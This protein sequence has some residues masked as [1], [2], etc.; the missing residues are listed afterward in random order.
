M[1]NEATKYLKSL[2]S[3]DF[4]FANN[5][6]HTILDRLLRQQHHCLRE[7]VGNVRFMV[8]W[9][10][11]GRLFPPSPHPFNKALSETEPLESFWLYPSK[12][13]GSYIPHFPW[14]LMKYTASG[15]LSIWSF[16]IAKPVKKGS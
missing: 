15:F 9:V 5:T 6:K 8:L 11:G 2:E 13:E 10:M 4:Y 14:D 3:F 12:A 7:T 1:D 16:Q